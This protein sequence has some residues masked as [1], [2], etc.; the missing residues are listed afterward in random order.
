MGAHPFRGARR[1][2]L[3]ARVHLDRDEGERQA[4]AALRRSVA[5][6]ILAGIA[7]LLALLVPACLLVIAIGA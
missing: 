5:S 6:G 3:V 2:G 7:V 1:P 4:G